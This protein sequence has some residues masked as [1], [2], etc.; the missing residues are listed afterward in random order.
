MPK[1]RD[2]SSELMLQFSVRSS[3]QLLHNDC[4]DVIYF[5]KN[6]C[7]IVLPYM[8][9]YWE[10]PFYY[11]ELLSPADIALK[12]HRSI[13]LPQNSVD[14]HCMKLEI[15]GQRETG[16]GAVRLLKKSLHFLLSFLGIHFIFVDFVF[17]AQ[18]GS[19]LI[20]NRDKREVVPK[21]KLL[22]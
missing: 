18:L 21:K 22:L 19:L 15:V 17:F 16:L 7:P 10:L 1:P 4:E 5:A 2:G 13:Q 8:C 14:L 6:F 12:I 11:L 20:V 3:T 9:L